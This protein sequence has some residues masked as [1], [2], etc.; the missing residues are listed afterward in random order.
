MS[1]DDPVNEGIT[2]TVLYRD[3]VDYGRSDE[4][5]VFNVDKMLG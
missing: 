2:Y 3:T 1:L 5:L 4:E